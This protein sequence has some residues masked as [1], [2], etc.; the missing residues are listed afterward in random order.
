MVNDQDQDVRPLS[1]ADLGNHPDWLAALVELS[2]CCSRQGKVDQAN[3]V[4][5]E[6]IR[7]FDLISVAPHPLATSLGLPALACSS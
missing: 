2:R 6:A 5:D 4:C 3:A 1:L 7:G